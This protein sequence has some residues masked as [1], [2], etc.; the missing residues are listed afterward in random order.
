MLLTFS[1]HFFVGFPFS[2]YLAFPFFLIG[3]LISALIPKSSL[4]VF[5]DEIRIPD[6][7]S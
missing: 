6:V 1:L 5:F 4:L 3:L 2:P 7:D